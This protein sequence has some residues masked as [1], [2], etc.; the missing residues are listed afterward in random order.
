[1]SSASP[2]RDDPTWPIIVSHPPVPSDSWVMRGEWRKK[3]EE[4]RNR[5]HEVRS[6]SG[7]QETGMANMTGLYRNLRSL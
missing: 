7:D 2:D 3:R 4:E 6:E 5:S 1:M